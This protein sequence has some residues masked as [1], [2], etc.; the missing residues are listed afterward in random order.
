MQVEDHCNAVRNHQDVDEDHDGGAEYDDNRD[1][2]KLVQVDQGS[3]QEKV[4][5][6]QEGFNDDHGGLAAVEADGQTA[7]NVAELDWLDGEVQAFGVGHHSDEDH[8][9]QVDIHVVVC[10]VTIFIAHDVEHEAD[11]KNEPDAAVKKVD[12]LAHQID[13]VPDAGFP[14]LL[15]YLLLGV[16]LGVVQLVK[17]TLLLRVAAFLRMA[18]YT[19]RSLVNARAVHSHKD[20]D[21]REAYI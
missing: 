3:N 21:R 17:F 15:R 13:V 20:A 9:H 11:D 18:D 7:Q 2:G 16:D 4:K 19:E 6:V 12:R 5:N 14:L 8:V 10:Q 1:K